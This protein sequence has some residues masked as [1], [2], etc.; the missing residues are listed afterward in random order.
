MLLLAVAAA[1]VL[2]A[3]VSSA[4]LRRLGRGQ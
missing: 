2:T 1:G 4:S 3:A